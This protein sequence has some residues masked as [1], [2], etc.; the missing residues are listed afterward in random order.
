MRNLD[1]NISQLY[2]CQLKKKLPR[3]SLQNAKIDLMFRPNVGQM[4]L[5][6]AFLKR[7]YKCKRAKFLLDGITYW[8]LKVSDPTTKL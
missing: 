2:N 3:P 6:I 5:I 7:K 4:F 1:I 8:V